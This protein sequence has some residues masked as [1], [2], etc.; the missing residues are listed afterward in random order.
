MYA[1]ALELN[2]LKKLNKNEKKLPFIYADKAGVIDKELSKRRHK[3]F[4]YSVA[5]IDFDDV[6]QI[7]RAHIHKKWHQWDPIS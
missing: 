5:W 7:I 1:K 2:L 3:W 6:C 4:L